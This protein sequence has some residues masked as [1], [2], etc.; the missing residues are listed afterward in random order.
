[1]QTQSQNSSRSSPKWSTLANDRTLG[2]AAALTTGFTSAF[3]LALIHNAKDQFTSVEVLT[4]RSFTFIILAL[5][6]CLPTIRLIFQRSAALLWFR[7]LLACVALF[8]LF[9]ATQQAPIGLVSALFAATPLVVYLMAKVILKE[10]MTEKHAIGSAIVGIGIVAMA[11]APGIEGI[12]PF[13][14]LI[15]I[16]SL[17]FRA[18]SFVILRAGSTNLP[19]MHIVLVLSICTGLCGLML[20]ADVNKLAQNAFNMNLLGVGFSSALMQWCLTISYRKLPAGQAALF[21]QSEVI[22]AF[23][24]G[25]LFHAYSPTVIEWIAVVIIVAGAIWSQTSS[26]KQVAPSTARKGHDGGSK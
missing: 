7:G 5:P 19:T 13:I 21:D 12:A 14:V 15:C 26:P 23:L 6:V 16:V 20:G 18:C 8:L 4:F 22:W 3:M 17:V 2:I 11:L 25:Y 24:F 1:M 10:E 9:Y